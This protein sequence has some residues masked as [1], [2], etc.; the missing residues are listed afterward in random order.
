VNPLRFYGISNGSF[1]ASTDGGVSFAALATGLPVPAQFKAVPGREGDVWVAGGTET[2]TYGLWHSTNGGATFAR[3]AN[4]EEADNIGFGLAR[5]A[6]RIPAL[7]TER[8]GGGVRGI[9]R[10]TNAGGTWTRINDAQHQYGSTG[11]R[12]RATRASSA[13]VPVDERTRD[14]LWRRG[15]GHA[16]LLAV[17]GAGGALARARRVRAPARSRSRARAGSRRA[18]AFSATGCRRA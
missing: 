18:V 4:L 2:T 14:R 12:S 7:Y 11:G 9:Y 5:R 16:G 6:R 15:S 1:Y 10:S 3:L 8:A 13:R 17:G